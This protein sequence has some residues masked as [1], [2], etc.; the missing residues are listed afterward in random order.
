VDQ[1]GFAR[2]A[3]T[4][5]D[6]GA[7]EYLGGVV[8][9]RVTDA[10]SGSPVAGAKLTAYGLNTLTDTNGMYFLAGLPFNSRSTC[11]PVA[12]ATSLALRQCR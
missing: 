7:F 10:R 6:M 3:G 11:A 5:C 8:T 4:L 1:R 12:L 2:P 9:G